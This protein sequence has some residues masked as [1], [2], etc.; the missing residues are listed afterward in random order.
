MNDGNVTYY[1]N[2]YLNPNTLYIKGN[3]DFLELKN[4]LNNTLTCIDAD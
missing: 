2:D 1:Y 4:A 3:N